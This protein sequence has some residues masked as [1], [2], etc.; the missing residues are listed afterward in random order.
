LRFGHC[1]CGQIMNLWERVL[2]CLVNTKSVYA[3]LAWRFGFD[4]LSHTQLLCP[5][6]RLLGAWKMVKTTV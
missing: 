6:P 3:L 4:F 1:C 5:H 2:N